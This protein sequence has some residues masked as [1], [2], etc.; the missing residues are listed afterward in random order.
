MESQNPWIGI[1]KNILC[2]E[3]EHTLSLEPG[4]RLIYYTD[5]ITETMDE[6]REQLGEEGLIQYVRD[7]QAIDLFDV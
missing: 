3:S 4:D 6:H 1:D 7:T 2:P 5:G